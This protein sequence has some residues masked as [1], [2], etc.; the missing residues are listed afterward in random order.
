MLPKQ[1]ICLGVAVRG[2]ILCFG[3]FA[4]PAHARGHVTLDSCVFTIGKFCPIESVGISLAAALVL[5]VIFGGLA[6]VWRG[7]T[8]QSTAEKALLD[9]CATDATDIASSWTAYFR[10]CSNPNLREALFGF[11]P[12]AADLLQREYPPIAALDAKTVTQ[13][14]LVGVKRAR[15]HLSV[16]IDQAFSERP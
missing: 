12:V 9:R 7:M 6:F 4:G 16:E 1:D 3:L 8:G 14:L 10:A 5:A 11:A 13:L 2:A 15:T